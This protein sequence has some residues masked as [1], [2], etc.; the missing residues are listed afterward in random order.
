MSER[1]DI[2]TPSEKPLS[3]LQAVSGIK[4]ALIRYDTQ[5]TSFN[6]QSYSRLVKFSQP[7]EPSDLKI[8]LC[9]QT[10]YPRLFWMN[11]EKDFALAGI[12]VADTI[13]SEGRGNN[14]SCFREFGKIISEKN[15]EALYFG[16]FRFNNSEIQEPIWK[17]FSSFCFVLP[18]VQLSFENNAYHLSCHLWLEKNDNIADRISILSEA[19][20]KVNF[21]T[22][23][24]SL[25]LPE[26]L[27]LSYNP[28]EKNWHDT[29]LKAI[30]TFESGDMEKIMLARQTVLEFKNSFSPFLFLIRYPY[31]KNA[32]YNFYFEPSENH[33]FFSFTPERL[34]RRDGNS[35]LTEALAGTCSKDTINGDQNDA[36]EALLNSE[37]DIR[38]HKF[39]KDMIYEELLEVSSDIDMEEDV[40][41]LQL[42]RLAHLYTH[43]SAKLKPEFENDSAV[44]TTLHPTP[45]VGGVPKAPALRHITEL[46]PFSRGW[47]A[48]PVGWVSRNA[49]EF[50]V[51]IR[52]ALV[53]GNVAYLY[54]GAGLVRGSDP[55]SE[56]EEVDQKIG[57]LL[58]ITRQNA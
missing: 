5:C 16:G 4:S 29:C 19:L 31:P 28:D 12:G 27:N 6:G 25:K 50:S 37:K 8:W 26:L 18:L 13:R 22:E 48:G 1:Y 38:E 47:Y 15:P 23:S 53:D 56:W 39:V 42:N 51:G 58:A 46:E 57:D 14:E 55:A 34:Y 7:V 33:A 17:E 44:L 41:V 49:A 40:R 54:S 36:S 45:A 30:E 52:S 20:D 9:N 11:R 32:I 24:P 43:C 2:I 35:L 10:I 3:L 21:S